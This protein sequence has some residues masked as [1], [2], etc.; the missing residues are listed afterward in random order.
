MIHTRGLSRTFKTKT[1]V[2]EAVAPLDLD[3]AP[4]E[5]VGLLGPNGAGKTT[6]LRMLTTVLSPTAGTGHRG[7]GGPSDPGT[8]GSQADRLRGSGR[9][10][11]GARVTCRRGAH[12]AG[13]TA[14]TVPGRRRRAGR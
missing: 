13:P 2:V 6:T 1:G 7:R 10:D 9:R 8:G 3:V 12:H 4:G 5:I 14:G 11:P